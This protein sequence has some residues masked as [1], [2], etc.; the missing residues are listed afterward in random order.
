[1]MSLRPITTAAT[2]N[3]LIIALA[4]LL[5][6]LTTGKPS[7]YFG[8]GRFTTAVSCAQL[9]AIAFFSSRI[10]LAR[11]PMAAPLGPISGAWVW[12]FIAA[13]FGFLAADDAFEIHERLD[14]IIHEAFHIQ[15]T[16]WT[17]RLDDMIIALYGCLGFSILWLFRRE[18]LFFK[19]MRRPLAG[20]FACLFV[21]VACDTISNDEHFLIWLFR[22]T[23]TAKRLNTWFAA[24]DGALTLLA[25]GF[26]LAAFYLSHRS[27]IASSHHTLRQT[28]SDG[29]SPCDRSGHFSARIAPPSG[30]P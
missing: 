28:A 15:E 14:R 6:L 2:A 17:D 26:F 7:R 24:G 9:L 21:S 23:A 20:G 13:G 30:D 12:G 4:I 16:A 1:M 18:I 10:F 11:R 19:P 22:D 3:L 25:E 5:G 27:A 8:E 29:D